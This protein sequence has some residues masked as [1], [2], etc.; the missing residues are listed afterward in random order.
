MPPRAAPPAD[1]DTPVIEGG[2][3][4]RM[5]RPE[6]CFTARHAGLVCR[7]GPSLQASLQRRSTLE[8][9]YKACKFCR[10][11]R[12]SKEKYDFSFV[13]LGVHFGVSGRRLRDIYTGC[14]LYTNNFNFKRRSRHDSRSRAYTRATATEFEPLAVPC[15]C[16]CRRRWPASLQLNVECRSSAGLMCAV[17][18]AGG[19][20]ASTVAAKAYLVST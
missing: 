18:A 4:T 20:L 16:T 17:L 5:G 8:A 13:F 1:P 14:R 6:V 10:T 19:Q 9:N 3:V 2:Y 15:T 7:N 11:R 12:R